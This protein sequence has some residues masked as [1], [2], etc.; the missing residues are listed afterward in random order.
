MG[1]KAN[2]GIYYCEKHKHHTKY[3]GKPFCEKCIEEEVQQMSKYPLSFDL[4]KALKRIA[5]ASQY[6]LPDEDLEW[7][8]KVIEKNFDVD[9]FEDERPRI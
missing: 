8:Y 4:K 5:E 2:T 6:W 7:S 3:I 9:L 1:K